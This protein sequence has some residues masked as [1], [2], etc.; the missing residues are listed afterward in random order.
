[1][2]ELNILWGGKLAETFLDCTV[3]DRCKGSGSIPE[4]VDVGFVR[5]HASCFDVVDDADCFLPSFSLV[6]HMH[7]V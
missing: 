1:M 5:T 6:A 3:F 4:N 2:D 7:M